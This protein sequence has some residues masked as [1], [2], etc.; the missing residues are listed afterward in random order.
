MKIIKRIKLAR[1]HY[2]DLG[3][4]DEFS[5]DIGFPVIIVQKRD[6][7]RDQMVG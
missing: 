7:G 4:G 6:I 2:G 1:I 5:Y 3:L